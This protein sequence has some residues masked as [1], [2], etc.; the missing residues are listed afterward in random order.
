MIV[1][2]SVVTALVSNIGATRGAHR[3]RLLMS[4]KLVIVPKKHAS[5]SLR[6]GANYSVRRCGGNQ[7]RMPASNAIALRTRSTSAFA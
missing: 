4:A 5:N 1:Y 7:A 3:P 2:A 6:I